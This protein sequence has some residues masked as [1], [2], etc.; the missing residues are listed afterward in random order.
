MDADGRMEVLPKKEQ[1]LL[2]KELAK[3]Q[4]NLNG[5]RNMKQLPD[6]IFVVDTNREQIA[7]HEAKRLGI[8]VVGTSTPTATPDDVEFGIPPTTTPS[9]RSTCSAPSLPTL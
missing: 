1:I 9:V 8:P 4:T 2:Q 3:L 5:I 6:A 7:I